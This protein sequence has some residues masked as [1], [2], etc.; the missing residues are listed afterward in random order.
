MPFWPWTRPTSAWV[1]HGGWEADVELQD[2][3]RLDQIARAGVKSRAYVGFYGVWL[4]ESPDLS[5]ARRNQ[6]DL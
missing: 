6:S 3:R 1:G 5:V 4:P 2:H